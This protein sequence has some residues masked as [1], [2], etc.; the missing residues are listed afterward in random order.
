M[1][2]Q[3]KVLATIFTLLIRLCSVYFCFLRDFAHFSKLYP[4]VLCT[5]IYTCCMIQSY[6]ISKGKGRMLYDML[7]LFLWSFT[8]FL[9]QC[10]CFLHDIVIEQMIFVF[11]PFA[12]FMDGMVCWYDLYLGISYHSNV[13][14]NHFPLQLWVLFLF[15][16]P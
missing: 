8:K 2:N 5:F 16:L 6:S 12:L 9:I 1:Q 10:T 11:S 3:K 15:F 7:W 14:H 13:I 4:E